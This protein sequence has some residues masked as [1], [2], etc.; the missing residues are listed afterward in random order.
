MPLRHSNV[1]ILLYAGM[2]KRVRGWP[3][4]TTQALADQP[5]RQASSRAATAPWIAAAMAPITTKIATMLAP[6]ICARDI[7]RR[8]WVSTGLPSQ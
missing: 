4:G 1:K 3:A 2:S 7:E 5:S 6:T 8:W